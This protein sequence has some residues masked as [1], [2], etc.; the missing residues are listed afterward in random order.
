MHDFDIH[1]PEIKYV[2]DDKNTC[3]LS[4]MVSALF[5]VNEHISEYAVVYRLSPFLLFDTV[6]FMNRLNFYSDII[7]YCDRNKGEQW[8]RYK[9]VQ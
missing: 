6:Y 5:A 8:C 7:T 4:V 3:C 1:A 2:Q 9:L